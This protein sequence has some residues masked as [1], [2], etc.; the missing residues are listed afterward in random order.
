MNSWE[1][2][3]RVSLR[4][5]HYIC[6][7]LALSKKD[8]KGHGFNATCWLLSSPGLPVGR[9]SRKLFP[10]AVSMSR[11]IRVLRGLYYPRPGSVQVV[12]EDHSETDP[13][14]VPK[15]YSLLGAGGYPT[16]Y[17]GV[18]YYERGLVCIMKGPLYLIVINRRSEMM[19][20]KGCTSKGLIVECL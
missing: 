18:S 10:S 6:K 15:F 19:L 1:H 4:L 5:N 12:Y 9:P 17:V 13:A 20:S 2:Q 3:R 14:G 7:C 16:V 11:I 8:S